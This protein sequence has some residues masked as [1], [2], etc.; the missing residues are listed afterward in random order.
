MN[1]R[2]ECAA[3][4]LC[5]TAAPL[6]AQ[7]SGRLSGQLEA[8]VDQVS[9]Y[10]SR[11]VADLTGGWHAGHIRL[12]A[13]YGFRYW[14]TANA[15]T[16]LNAEA[17]RSLERVHGGTATY[18]VGKCRAG[19]GG[20]P[21]S[22]RGVRQRRAVTRAQGRYHPDAHGASGAILAR[23]SVQFTSASLAPG[24][25]HQGAQPRELAVRQ[26]LARQLEERGHRAYARTAE[27]RAQ[28]TLQR[29]ALRGGVRYRRLVHVAHAVAPGAGCLCARGS[30]ASRAR[31]SKCQ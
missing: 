6:S 18:A 4:L 5:A 20:A 13:Y 3:A 14:T 25:A 27:E 2:V 15:P 7:F 8:W 17:G 28:Q 22:R 12:D 11:V 29:G 31:R 9:G 19:A 26:L 24:A 16:F 1:R 10:N 30:A 23:S 21:R